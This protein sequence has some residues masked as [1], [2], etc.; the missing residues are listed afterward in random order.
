MRLIARYIALNGKV[1]TNAPYFSEKSWIAML[2]LPSDKTGHC[3]R[4][5]AIFIY[6]VFSNLRWLLNLR[7]G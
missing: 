6:I 2:A 7:P 1:A 3:G 5:M 4:S